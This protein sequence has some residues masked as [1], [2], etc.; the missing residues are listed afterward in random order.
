MATKS[1]S[2]TTSSFDI[3]GFFLTAWK[4]M[5]LATRAR[6]FAPF[7]ARPTSVADISN[8]TPDKGFQPSYGAAG[9]QDLDR[10]GRF[11]P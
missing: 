8:F 11:T 9:T 10:L 3:G 4:I 5:V 6:F 2:S 1:S 7:C